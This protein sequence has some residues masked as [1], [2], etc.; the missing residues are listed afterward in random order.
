M[1]IFDCLVWRNRETAQFEPWLA[2]SWETVDDQT[3]RF[4]LRKGVTFHN[5]EPF[6]AEAVKYTYDR[7]RADKTMITYNQWTFMED[8]KVLDENQVEI[9]TTAPEPAMLSK[10]S[11]TGCG[12]QAP[13]HGEKVGREGVAENPVGTGPFKFVEWVKDDHI[14]LAANEDYWKGKPEVDTIVFR[15]IPESTTRVSSLLAGE[16]DLIVSVPAQDIERVN[17]ANGINV[18]EFLTTQVMMLAMRA[19]PNEKFPDWSGPTS[20]PRIR[21]AIKL[22]IDRTALIDLIGGDGIPVLSRITPPTLG[23]N[24]QFIGK[25]GTPNLERARALM[26]EAGYNG[27][28]ITFH[29]STSWPNQKEVAEVI[30]G[31]LEA[32]GFNVNLQVMDVTSFREQVYVPYKNEELYMDALGNSFFDPWIAVLADRSD[33]R[34]R[35]GWSGEL[36][37]QMDTLIREAA[38]NMDADARA[39]QYVKLQELQQSGEYPVM[40][41][42]QMQDNVGLS[43]TIE[44]QPSQDGFLWLGNVKWVK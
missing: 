15:A 20:D 13:A 27:E 29:S 25:T 19:G 28:E 2:E 42:Y 32:V 18:K 31:M 23:S 3:W 37:D 36:A 30:A 7:I 35:S 12:I 14:T 9:R 4:T 1:N 10:M 22:S 5:G 16:V 21:E 39:A 33:R 8:V 40:F 34:E 26:A 43:E 17:A 44:W 6:N 24:D 41:L 11:G 38:V